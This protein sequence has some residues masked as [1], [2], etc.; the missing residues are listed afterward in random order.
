M[1]VPIYIER[2]DTLLV[3]IPDKTSVGVPFDWLTPALVVSGWF[4]AAWLL[5]KQLRADGERQTKAFRSSLMNEARQRVVRELQEYSTWLSLMFDEL[6]YVSTDGNAIGYMANAQKLNEG[7]RFTRWSNA[8]DE[9]DQLFPEVQGV[10][11]KM[12][13]A[14]HAMNWDIE[15]NFD[16]STPIVS[17]DVRM[18]KAMFWTQWIFHQ[19][20]LV[21]DLVVH[22][23][24]VALSEALDREPPTPKQSDR[25]VRLVMKNGVFAIEA[26]GEAAH[27]YPYPGGSI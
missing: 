6:K 27:Q 19:G 9:Y 4:F 23:Q 11:Q 5:R 16:P 15:R 17:P 3:H 24:R 8:L 1:I 13:E 20:G 14:H 22:I 25:P 7:Q 2:T 10:A 21:N 18:Q 12:N 26:T